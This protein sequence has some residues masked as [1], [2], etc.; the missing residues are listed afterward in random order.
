MSIRSIRKMKTDYKNKEVE[1]GGV[2]IAGRNKIPCKAEIGERSKQHDNF[3]KM[4]VRTSTKKSK[5]YL[6]GPSIAERN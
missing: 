2:I 1:N 5:A 3:K 4:G 6:K